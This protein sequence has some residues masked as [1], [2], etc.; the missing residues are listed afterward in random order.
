MIRSLVV[1]KPTK[2][3]AIIES[4]MVALLFSSS[5]IFVKIGLGYMGPLTLAGSRSLLAFLVLL[6]FMVRNRNVNRPLT[7]GLWFRLLLIGLLN[8]TFG[9]GAIF[10]SLKYL[11]PTTTSFVLTLLPLLTMFASILWL[12][13][14][15]TRLQVLGVVVALGGS[16]MFLSSGM[17]AGE[18]LGLGIELIGLA[19]LLF[20][21][22]LSRGVARNRQVDTLSLTAIPLALGGGLTLS[23]AFLLEG[24]PPLSMAA[25]GVVLFMAVMNTA[26]AFM[27]YNH[28]LQVLTALELNVILSL[29]LLGT[30]VLAWL[31]LDEKLS[32]IEIIG[33]LTVIVGVIVSQRGSRTSAVVSPG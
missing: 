6:P 11:S 18:P 33:M 3:T 22:I 14:L 13:E 31:L 24:P 16:W 30:A 27:L 28:S 20:A 17:Q 7:L 4:L 32:I 25:W 21:G 5:F 1:G 2:L 15:P 19:G 26:L 10:W 23:V 29:S 9:F 8:Y 12:K